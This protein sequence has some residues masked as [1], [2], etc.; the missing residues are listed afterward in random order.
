MTAQ[1]KSAVLYLRCSTLNQ[2]VE[3]VSIQVQKEKAIQWC[4]YNG[5]SIKGIFSD[6][7]ISGKSVD[8]REGVQ[9]ALK[10]VA[11][12]DALVFYSL[13]RLARSTKETIEISENLTKR[14]VDLI[15]LKENIDTTTATGRMMFKML[16]VLAEFERELTVERTCDAMQR[17]KADNV[18]IGSIPFGFDAVP[19]GKK[20][21]KS[22]REEKLLVPNDYEQSV[23]TRI[24]V[25]R[26]TNPS[27]LL[28]FKKIALQLEK[29]GVKT[30]KGTT[31]WHATSIERILKVQ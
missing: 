3:G 17:M 25:L 15:S 31:N 20:S 1:I 14:G 29:E 12:G 26:H 8:K 23:I 13:S 10:S 18:L 9:N 22:G 6:E 11:K 27:K 30:R 19:T 24:K 16:A 7:G 21:E 28:S 4:E 2:A 5:Y